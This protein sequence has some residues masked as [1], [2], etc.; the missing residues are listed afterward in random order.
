MQVRFS[1]GVLLASLLTSLCLAAAPD[2]ITS[3]ILAAQ[4]VRLTGGVPM[5]ARSEFDAGSVDPAFRMTVTLLTVPSAEGQQALTQ[6]LSDQQNPQSG[7]F[8]KWLTP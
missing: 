6:L 8:H 2:R 1:L 3:P 4:T 5:Q 7:S